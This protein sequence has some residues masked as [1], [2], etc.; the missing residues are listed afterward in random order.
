[1]K[2]LA[3]WATYMG[4][5]T[6][7][8]MMLGSGGVVS[9]DKSYF[10]HLQEMQ[11][12]IVNHSNIA[13]SMAELVIASVYGNNEVQL[14]RPLL[15]YDETDRWLVVGSYNRARDIEGHGPIKVWI[16]KRDAKVIDLISPVVLKMDP[17]AR[18]IVQQEL[19]RRPDKR[20]E[21]T[22]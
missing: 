14:Q 7:C 17:E 22:E 8:L 9:E 18:K 12:G 20:K 5:A 1:M 3:N 15:A 2:S 10:L 13:I 4:G 11:G 19:K 21:N 6:A 16:R